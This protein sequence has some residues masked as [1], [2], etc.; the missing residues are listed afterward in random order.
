MTDLQTKTA[1]EH[2]KLMLDAQS[3]FKD[4]SETLL[5]ACTPMERAAAINGAESV[6]ALFKKKVNKANKLNRVAFSM[7]FLICHAMVSA[8]IDSAKEDG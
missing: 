8:Y 4:M 7:A 1:E 2:D 3:E 6:M 5:D